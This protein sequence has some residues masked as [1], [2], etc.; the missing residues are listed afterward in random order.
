M[1]FP[2]DIAFIKLLVGVQGNV[3]SSMFKNNFG[4]AP[5]LKWGFFLNKPNKVLI[6]LW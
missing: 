2:V 5:F 4:M 6:I 1:L 3:G